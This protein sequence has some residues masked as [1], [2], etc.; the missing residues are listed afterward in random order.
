MSRDKVLPE[1]I[2][3]K[4]I[5]EINKSNL[6][7]VKDAFDKHGLDFW[8]IQ[9]TFLGLYRDG[10][11]IPWDNDVDLAI[12]SEDLPLLEQTRSTLEPLGFRYIYEPAHPIL[13][14]K[15]GGYER[16]G[17]AIDVFF[18][19]KRDNRRVNRHITQITQDAFEIYN[20]LEYEGREFRIFHEPERWLT[21]FYGDWKTPIRNRHAFDGSN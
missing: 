12:R 16:Y 17:V 10:D 18:F 2:D 5:Y 20:E 19:E 15:H 8:L 6:L 3:G 9:G 1:Y 11:I 4:T 13:L 14:P 21:Y 7:E